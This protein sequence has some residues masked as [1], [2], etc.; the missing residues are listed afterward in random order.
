[1]LGFGLAGYLLR[2]LGFDG[3]P[4]LLALVLGPILETNVRLSLI[5]SKG[6]LWLFVS[7]PLSLLL[8]GAAALILAASVVP[9]LR[10]QWRRL[11]AA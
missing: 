9:G 2:R 11:A 7:R 1:M 3:A 8:L 10:R 4:F 5:I 6:D